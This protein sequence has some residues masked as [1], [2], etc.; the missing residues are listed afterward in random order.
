MGLKRGLIQLYTGNS[1]HMNFA[2]MG[3]TLRAAGHGLRIY[4]TCFLPHEYMDGAQMASILLKPFFVAKHTEIHGIKEGRL[5]QSDNV[6]KIKAS[7]EEAAKAVVSGEYDIVILNNAVQILNAGIISM[8]HILD[9]IKV[10]PESVELVFTGPGASEDLIHLADLVTDMHCRFHEKEPIEDFDPTTNAPIEVVTGN[11]KGKTTYCLGKAMYMSCL[12]AR[13]SILQFIKSPKAYGEVR[14]IARMPYV[15]IR[16]MGEGFPNAKSSKPSSKHL[17][18]ARRAWEECLREI[19]SLKYGLMVFDEIN[20]AIKYGF[21]HEERV[22]E[23]LFLKPHG[24]HLIL[25]GRDA[26]PEVLKGA[27]SIIEMREIKHP[28]KKGIKARKGIE[29]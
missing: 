28:F 17:E 23:M 2:P 6:Q 29:F 22:R 10:K 18:A 24:L 13:T 9:L 4:M 15:D 3:L 14:A 11:G 21:V 1:D 16:S 27:T 5:W 26:P 20:I 12:G 7:Y 25:S 19:F 8:D